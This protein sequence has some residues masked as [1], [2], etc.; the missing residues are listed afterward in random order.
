M[1]RLRTAGKVKLYTL[2]VALRRVDAIHCAS[3]AHELCLRCVALR[4]VFSVNLPL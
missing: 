2:G 4:Y 3:H 1:L